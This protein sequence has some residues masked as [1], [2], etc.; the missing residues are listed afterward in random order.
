MLFELYDELDLSEALKHS[1][2][3]DTCFRH[4]IRLWS[5]LI[6]KLLTQQVFY[7]FLLS[8]FFILLMRNIA[9]VFVRLNVFLDTICKAVT[10][11]KV[12]P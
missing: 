4:G 12:Q 6:G 9:K 2:T 5:T 11:E 8:P 7:P 1:V 10:R 3:Q